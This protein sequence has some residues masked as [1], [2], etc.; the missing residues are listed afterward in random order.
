[1]NTCPVGI[2]QNVARRYMNLNC[3][4]SLINNRTRETL[5]SARTKNG[6]SVSH[7]VF[8]KDESCHGIVAVLCFGIR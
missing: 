7:G 3:H 2:S 4:F 1:M 6:F 5:F 8:G